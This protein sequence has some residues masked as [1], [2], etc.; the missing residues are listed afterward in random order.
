MLEGM[1]RIE[2]DAYML[3]ARLGATPVSRILTAGGGAV[4]NKW[5][6]LR[7]A[8]MGVPVDAAQQGELEFPM[9]DL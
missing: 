6:A 7:A 2:A 9:F 3:L 1:A 5:T 8:A 4:N